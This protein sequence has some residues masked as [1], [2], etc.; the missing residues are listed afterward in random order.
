MQVLSVVLFIETSMPFSSNRLEISEKV[1]NDVPSNCHL[2]P[3]FAEVIQPSPSKNL[4]KNLEKIRF[5][6][7]YKICLRIIGFSWNNII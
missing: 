4:V 5:N 6:I 1:K 7:F 3:Q 2:I